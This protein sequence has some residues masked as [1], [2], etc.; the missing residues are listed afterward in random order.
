MSTTTEAQAPTVTPLPSG[1]YGWAPTHEPWP[2]WQD[3]WSTTPG[4]PELCVRIFARG[5]GDTWQAVGRRFV[6]DLQV[7]GQ[8]GRRMAI[9]NDEG[10]PTE[11][12][13]DAQ[14]ATALLGVLPRRPRPPVT[15][16]A[17]RADRKHSGRCTSAE[18]C[19]RCA[20][21]ISDAEDRA[22]GWD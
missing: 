10:K 17:E 4:K 18:E 7:W 22:R 12:V 3:P 21:A 9:H 8:A 6:A 5:E 20:A 13:L 14:D 2:L 15:V 1:A 16:Y 19:A 11:H